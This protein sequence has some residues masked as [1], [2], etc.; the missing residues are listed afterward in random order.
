MSKTYIKEE[1]GEK[2]LYE[3]GFLGD[4]KIGE[5]HENFDG[6]LE[7]RNAFSE[8]YHVEQER[9]SFREVIETVVPLSNPKDYIIESSEGQSGT[10]EY[11]SLRGRHEGELENR[12]N[13]SGTLD[14]S[15][16]SNSSS[17]SSYSH[18]SKKKE[19]GLAEKVLIAGRIQR[20]AG[21]AS[22]IGS[23][24]VP[25]LSSSFIHNDKT[26]IATYYNMEYLGVD[27]IALGIVTGIVGKILE[28]YRKK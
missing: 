21:Y 22:L 18:S 25:V 9:D 20:W 12:A 13:D 15:G 3:E 23:C 7:T 8:N 2:V 19:K 28:N 26:A 24:V 14:T 4:R 5:L 1:N 16:Y 27:L 17:E 10:L 11:E 6:S